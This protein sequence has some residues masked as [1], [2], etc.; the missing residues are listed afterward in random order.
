MFIFINV[1]FK[2]YTSFGFLLLTNVLTGIPQSQYKTVLISGTWRHQYLLPTLTPCL[3]FKGVF[4]SHP[5]RNI[6]K[7][8][9]IYII[10]H[11]VLKIRKILK[12]K[13]MLIKFHHFWVFIWNWFFCYTILKNNTRCLNRWK[14]GAWFLFSSTHWFEDKGS[15]LT[16]LMLID[17]NIV[18]LLEGFNSIQ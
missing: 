1:Q 5:D 2:W 14:E 12:N 15:L 18:L 8:H 4:N 11:P 6:L 13:K 16:T 10:M 3:R 7:L 17:C 9:H